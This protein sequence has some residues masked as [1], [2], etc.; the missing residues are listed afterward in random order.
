MNAA[1]EKE[2]AATDAKVDGY[3][4]NSALT[5]RA[6]DRGKRG[7]ELSRR[8][9]PRRRHQRASKQVLSLTAKRPVERRASLF[10]FADTP[11]VKLTAKVDPCPTVLW[12]RHQV[13]PR[14]HLAHKTLPQSLALSGWQRAGITKKARPGEEVH[15]FRVSISKRSPK[16]HSH[17]Q[18]T[19][20]L[21]VQRS[22]L[23]VR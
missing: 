10:L 18:S 6:R 8:K 20:S 4:N 17:T 1:G 7:R 21:A 13:Q 12:R 23:G 19:P 22:T 9:D 14:T 15:A 3:L 11:P 16:S 2:D 5:S